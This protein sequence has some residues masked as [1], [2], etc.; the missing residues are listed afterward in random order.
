MANKSKTVLKTYFETGDVPTQAQFGDL[1]DSQFNLTDNTMDNIPD[2]TTNRVFTDAEKT[3]LS[4]LA[5]NVDI[6]SLGANPNVETT[7]KLLINKAGTNYRVDLSDIQQ[8]FE[9]TSQ[10]EEDAIYAAHP[11]FP[12][13]VTRTD[14][15]DTTDTEAPVISAFVIPSTSSTLAI[16]ITTFTA[17]DNVAVTSYAI[18]LTNSA[19]STGWVTTKPTSYTVSAPGYYTLYAWTKDAAGNVS[20]SANDSCTIADSFLPTVTA[21]VIPSTGTA[22]EVTISTFTATDSTGVTGYIVTESGTKPASG[23]AGW[24]GTAQTTYTVADEGL[25]TLY[26]YAKDA[27]GNVSDGVSDQITITLPDTVAPTVT[28]FDCAATSSSLDIAINS[29]TATDNVAV[30]GYFV[31]E[32]SATPAYN[33]AGW[34]STAPGTY[35]VGTAGA[36]TLYGWAKDAGNNISS[37]VSD[38]CTVTLADS[39]APVV[40]AFVIPATASSKTVDITTFTATDAVG[41]SGYMV[42]EVSTPPGSGDAGWNGTAPSTV[43]FTTK[44]SQTGYAFAKDAAGNVSSAATD[45]VVITLPPTTVTSL[46]AT[47]GDTQ[48]VLNW[49]KPTAGADSDLATNYDVIWATDSGF[50]SPTTISDIG[51]VA[52]YTH[53]GRTNGTAYYYKIV[54]KNVAGSV[55]SSSVNAT[56]VVVISYDFNGTADS[57]IPSSLTAYTASTG[58]ARIDGSG[59][60]TLTSAAT[61]TGSVLWKTDSISLATAKTYKFI[62]RIMNTSPTVE[63]YINIEN[64]TQKYAPTDSSNWAT[65]SR[66]QLFFAYIYGD[67]SNCYVKPSYKTTSST[68]SNWNGSIWTTTGTGTTLSYN[69]DY[70]FLI[71]SNG[72]QMKMQ[73]KSADGNTTY[74][75][76]SYVDISSIH[77]VDNYAWLNV[78]DYRTNGYNGTIKINSYEEI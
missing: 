47:A 69:T 43:V 66:L 78:G 45:S 63:M 48:V 6:P 25:H 24:S 31:S 74:L 77:S 29:F 75:D 28:A 65:Y 23:D 18:T 62:M 56:P 52:T 61:T 57:A 73:I 4:D 54:A 35:H 41:V 10:E 15:I 32:S 11:N 36:K 53:T 3:Q 7:D 14:L 68:N 19:P 27:A 9:A 13:I 26:G 72:T 1:I 5:A 49:T 34:T 59:F 22:L 51:D 17:S 8:I 58:T 37:Y 20:T 12:V 60:L 16:P 44:G 76:T 67:G 50:T 55:Q 42:K 30:T 2:G 21:F 38:T 33:A 71:I 70:Q 39:T 64:A 40:T 46:S